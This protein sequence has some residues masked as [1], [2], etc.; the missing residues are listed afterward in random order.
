MTQCEIPIGKNLWN[1]LVCF[2]TKLKLKPCNNH[3]SFFKGQ[4]FNMNP[5]MFTLEHIFAMDLACYKDICIE[6]VG[7][8][9]KEMSIEHTIREVEKVPIF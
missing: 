2:K 3:Y 7:N 6:I 4:H 5:E 1:K 8:S 9:I